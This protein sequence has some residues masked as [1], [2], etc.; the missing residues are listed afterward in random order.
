[1]CNENS[2]NIED[3]CF[4][5]HGYI[6]CDCTIRDTQQN[7]KNIAL[8]ASTCI[9]GGEINPYDDSMDSS[10]MNIRLQIDNIYSMENI[11]KTLRLWVAIN[12]KINEDNVWIEI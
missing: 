5:N 4:C 9:E 8:K 6:E 2:T 3:Q 11:A 12:V 7:I 1:M 10:Q